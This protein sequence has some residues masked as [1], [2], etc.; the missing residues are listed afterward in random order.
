MLSIAPDEYVIMA[1]SQE[2]ART[3]I[4]R[5]AVAAVESELLIPHLARIAVIPAKNAEPKANI[6]H[7]SPRHFRPACRCRADIRLE[8]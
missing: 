2:K 5:T 4:V 6:I 7:I 8:V 1:I 3:T